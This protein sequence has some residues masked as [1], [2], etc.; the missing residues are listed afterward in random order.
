[1]ASMNEYSI[2]MRMLTRPGD[3]MGAG[4]DDMLDALGLPEDLGRHTLFQRLAGLQCRLRPLGMTVLYN[5]VSHVFYVDTTESQQSELPEAALSE[6]LAAT[7]LVVITLT[8]RSGDW[9]S[10]DEVRSL[11][12]KT[13]RGVMDDIRE[14]AA[15][16]Y[17]EFD[18]ANSRV[19]PGSR[20]GFEIDHEEFFR[21][22]SEG[23]S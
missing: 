17:L 9:V 8:Y 5:A 13:K 19:R 10:I 6:R 12:K 22:L 20:V 14:L 18:R 4:V 7:L 16:D 21:K 1:M 2:L 11:R 3:P 15:M 23:S